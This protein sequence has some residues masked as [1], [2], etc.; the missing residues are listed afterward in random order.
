[1]K[2]SEIINELENI[3]E[4]FGDGTVYKGVLSTSF[5]EVPTDGKV[6]ENVS[7]E[8]NVDGDTIKLE[9]DSNGGNQI[10]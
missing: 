7:I 4:A 10:R 8:M 1:M 2:L 5:T 6:I 9:F 3:R